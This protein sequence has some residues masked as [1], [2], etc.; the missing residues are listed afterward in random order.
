MMK[1]F[2]FFLSFFLFFI[3]LFFFFFLD[4]IID[5]CWCEYYVFLFSANYLLAIRLTE[6]IDLI[7]IARPVNV[8]R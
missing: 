3:L 4:K 7:A 5:L 6:W 8:R 1:N 2:S